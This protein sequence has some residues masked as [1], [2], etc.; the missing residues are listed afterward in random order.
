MK[1]F[2][3]PLFLKHLVLFIWPHQVWVVAQ[4]VC[5]LSCSTKDLLVAACK[6]LVTAHGVRFPD[7]GSNPSLL[8]WDRGVLATGPPG[9]P[10]RFPLDMYFLK[11]ILVTG[12]ASHRLTPFHL[13]E[14]EVYLSYLYFKIYYIRMYS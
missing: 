3:R 10:L 4:G 1:S 14:I 12:E 9:K 5:D 11:K 8:H 13:S 7:Q 2:L 6:L